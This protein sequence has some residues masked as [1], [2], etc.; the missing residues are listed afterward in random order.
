MISY[1]ASWRWCHKCQGLFFAA[2]PGS[3]G[4]CP[5]DRKAHD[6]SQSGKYVARTPAESEPSSKA[7]LGTEMLPFSGQQGGWR[8]CHKC[9]G[10]FFSET[11]GSQGTCPAD[12]KGHDASLSGH[13]AVVFD[14]GAAP[15]IG[16]I[17]WRWCHKC[18]G[19]F[20]G[21]NPTQGVCPVDG[22][23]HDASQSGPYQME[24]EPSRG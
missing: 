7:E 21:G 5:A 24:F 4:T 20:F 6:A 8:Y 19:F 17:H 16:Q 12:E 22:E 23:A 1:Q 14:D 13:Y 3:Q 18:Q 2:T 10:L 11:P 9:Q 15:P